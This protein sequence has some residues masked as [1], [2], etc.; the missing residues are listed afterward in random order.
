MTETYDYVV[1]GGGSA[2]CVV[3]SRLAQDSDISVCV[4]EA[5]PDDRGL[6]QVQDL[7]RWSELL[8]SELDFSYVIEPQAEGNSRL[9]HSRGRV[10]GGCS[11]HNSCIALQPPAADF[12]DWKARGAEGWGADDV[13]AAFARL[14]ARVHL[15]LG[16]VANP[17]TRDFIAS[18]AKA[19]YGSIDLAQPFH[20]GA[21]WLPLNKR[22]ATRESSSNAYLHQP[23][24]PA[25]LTINMESTA[26]GIRWG[27]RR[28][29]AV[30]LSDGNEIHV[31]GEL[32][33][34]AGAFDTPKLLLLSGVG[35][36]RELEAL[37][38]GVHLPLAG[39]GKHLLDHPEGVL[40][41]ELNRA[42]PKE[43]SQKYEAA[44]FVDVDGRGRADV[45]LHFGLE[46]FDMHT[47]AAGYPT[48]ENA[49]SLTPNV[50]YASSEGE[51]RLRSADPKDPALIDP[52]YFT[53][54]EGHDLRLMLEGFRIARAVAA[55]SP[56]ADWIRR[57]LA[58]GA[59]TFGREALANYLRRTHNTVYHPA[60]T[61]RMGRANEPTSVV[62][63][64]LH[65]IGSDNVR[66][67]DASVFPQMV[68]VNPNLTVMMIGERCAEFL[69]AS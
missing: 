14:L 61:C 5:G 13:A 1:V 15:E 21:G 53:D 56:L 20:E 40:I 38:I 64:T 11:S 49:F 65:L 33:L 22:G 7:S 55:Q 58:P 67:A 23:G 16:N 44:V 51:V 60:G 3:A 50:C 59:E 19:G 48:A 41:W 66:I 30:M 18:A 54:A 68:G 25:N 28:A 29:S 52:R 37:G 27:H 31:G 46:A 34:S 35:P 6:P 62:D 39:V 26:I 12:D 4:L 69:A 57:E 45:M 47:V 17:L 24:V 36:P 43:T 2:G 63:P 42:L 32:V 8:G 9:V 10:L